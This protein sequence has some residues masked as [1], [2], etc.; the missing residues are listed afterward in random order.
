MRVD[1]HAHV[2]GP[3]LLDVPWLQGDET[4]AIRRPLG[5]EQLEVELERDGVDRVVLVAA[6]ETDAG[7]L[8]LM[9]VAVRSDRVAAVVAWA[10]PAD[11]HT[12]E[13]VAHLGGRPGGERLR[14]VRVSAGRAGAAWWGSREVVAG[15][16]ALRDHGLVVEALVADDALAALAPVCRG[17][18]GLTLVVDHFGGPT[19]D[20][21]GSWA[22]GLHALAQVD[23]VQLKV[24]GAP[25]YADDATELL[26]TV[27]GAFGAPRLMAGS[28]W[29][30]STLHGGGAWRRVVAATAHWS[31]DERVSLL[32]GTASRVYGI[33]A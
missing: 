12:P 13:R 4:A 26:E 23:G 31:P 15:L 8:R 33:A 22:E 11:P 28:D 29:P 30:V 19:A 21:R 9:D 5:I 16:A 24:S 7:N 18:P 32:G 10:D 1:A 27:R 2:W 6:D 25:L 14:G 20:G 17:L 3:E